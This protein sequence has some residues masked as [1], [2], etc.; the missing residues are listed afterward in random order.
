MSTYLEELNA[1]KSVTVSGHGNVQDLCDKLAIACKKVDALRDENARL[2]GL[3]VTWRD[4]IEQVALAE[5]RGNLDGDDAATV[6]EQLNDEADKMVQLTPATMAD[7]VC[8]KREEWEA[9]EKNRKE[10]DMLWEDFGAPHSIRQLEAK[11]ARLTAEAEK[12]RGDGERLDWLEKLNKRL[13][14]RHG[15]VYQWKMIINE[16]VNRLFLVDLNDAEC[17]FGSF[18]TP[19][20]AIDAARQADAAGQKGG[21]K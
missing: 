10:W 21:G 12:L 19:R 5:D 16:N 11:L 14:E 7:F 17:G 20:A 3:V 4:F 9:V 18:A 13:N 1:P 15:T 2:K 6:L 8:V